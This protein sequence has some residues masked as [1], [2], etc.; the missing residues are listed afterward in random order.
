MALLICPKCGYKAVSSYA[1]FCPECHVGISYILSYYKKK[2]EPSIS[3]E[4]HLAKKNIKDYLRPIHYEFLE[5][6]KDELKWSNTPFVFSSTD[7]Y[8]GF[9][10]EEGGKLCAYIA[11]KGD[12][13]KFYSYSHVEKKNVGKPFVDQDIPKYKDYILHSLFNLPRKDN[14]ASSNNSNPQSS[15][16]KTHFDTI[17]GNGYVPDET[18]K[19]NGLSKETPKAT[20]IKM[21]SMEETLNDYYNRGYFS[22]RLLAVLRKE[23]DEKDVF[24]YLM[25]KN[26]DVR[27]S[28]LQEDFPSENL[29]DEQ[30][31][32]IDSFLKNRRQEYES[33]FSLGN[34]PKDKRQPDQDYNGYRFGRTSYIDDEGT[35]VESQDLG[36]LDDI[37]NDGFHGL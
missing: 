17:F 2:E 4:K 21:S 14:D 36:Y 20:Y 6:I 1:D 13:L 26:V 28:K 7:A 15:R 30:Y 12:T 35:V 16:T 8:M 33:Y 11:I 19:K 23:F 10:Y 29:N 31:L 5:D 24:V 37:I 18:N 22:A 25:L 27:L 9:R 3:K 34:K 32:K